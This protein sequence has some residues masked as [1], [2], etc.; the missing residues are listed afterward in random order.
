[1]TSSLKSPSSQALEYI[2]QACFHRRFILPATAEH[3]E[4]TVTYA[5]VGISPETKRDN[6]PTIIFIPGMFAT[7][8]LG[9]L[10]HQIAAKNGVR[11]LVIDR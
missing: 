7:R 3:E 1:M 5:D 10:I 2:S 11:V 8:Y 4:L 6:V 9:V